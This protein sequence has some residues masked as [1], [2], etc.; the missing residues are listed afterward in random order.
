MIQI[1]ER[2]F[3]DYLGYTHLLYK[4]ESF[5]KT[6]IAEQLYAQILGWA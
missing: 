1:N 6:E 5:P 2:L 3:L 4:Y